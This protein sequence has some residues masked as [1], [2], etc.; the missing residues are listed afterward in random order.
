MDVLFNFVIPFLVVLTIVVFVH[1]WGHYWVARR[2]GVR[3][4]VFS[5][6]FGHE[7]F[8]WNDRSGTRWKIGAIPLGGYVKMFGEAETLFEEGDGTDEE[9]EGEEREL[10]PEEK[11]VSFHHKRIG[12]RAAI[13]FAGPAINFLF[14]MV[15]ATL[16]AFFVGTASIEGEDVTVTQVAPGKPA[17]AAG[18]LPGD[19]VQAINGRGALNTGLLKQLVE[20]S[21]AKPLTFSV[22]RD[23]KS[24]DF[25][26]VPDA[27]TVDGG[28][29][30]RIG[31]G[32]IDGNTM[33]YETLG[34]VDSVVYGAEFT[35]TTIYRIFIF[36]G[37]MI[38]G[39]ESAEN[40][41]G[42]LGIAQITGNVWQRDFKDLVMFIA[43]LSINLGFVNLLPIPI[44]DGGHL[45]LYLAEALR[46]RPVGARAQE[47]GFRLG[48]VLVL[49]LIVFATWQDLRRLQVFEFLK[50]LIT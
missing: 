12:Q 2:N 17:E 25:T 1:E 16:M 6:G 4:E 26:V 23:D 44:L 37:R 38:G 50:D 20:A 9:G 34:P 24:L 43:M 13:V 27:A 18:I 39:E 10:T 11:A 48:L 31:I 46:G 22:R 30:G 36:V 49:L 41:A 33:V 40:L 32:M 5:V 14:A 29:V 8:G 15:L 7:I 47:Y 19:V 28:T 35:A 42:P 45:A 3:V 21:P